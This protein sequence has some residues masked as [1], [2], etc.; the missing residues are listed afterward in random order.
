M[1]DQSSQS[2]LDELEAEIVVLAGEGKRMNMGRISERLRS[3]AATMK[4]EDLKRKHGKE[5]VDVQ[6]LIQEF[7][8]LRNE[9]KETKEQNL[10]LRQQLEQFTNLT[11][12]FQK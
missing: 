4:R 1:G 10:R 6:D 5:E 9:V 7:Y 3:V 12:S 2:Q 11:K 8:D